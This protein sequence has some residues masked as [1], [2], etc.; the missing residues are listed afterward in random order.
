ME[1]KIIQILLLGTLSFAV[2][3]KCQSYPPL[4][5]KNYL[6]ADIEVDEKGGARI[7]EGNRGNVLV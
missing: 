6:P 1:M 4:K 5:I 3:I 2:N 7:T